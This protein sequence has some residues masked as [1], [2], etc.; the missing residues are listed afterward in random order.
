M[1]QLLE[2]AIAEVQKRPPAEQDAMAALILDELAD[3]QRWNEAFA[4]SQEELARIAAKVRDDIRAGRARDMG[5]D[6]L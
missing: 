2:Q 4:R 5:I 1:T 6:E 3:E